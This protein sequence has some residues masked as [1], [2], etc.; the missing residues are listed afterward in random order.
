MSMEPITYRL[1]F[2]LAVRHLVEIE[3]TIPTANQLRSLGSKKH[4]LPSQLTLMMSVWT[5]GSYLVREYARNIES[6]AAFDGET[7]APLSIRK[8]DKNSWIVDGFR[9]ETIRVVYSLYCREMSVRTNWIDEEF[10]LINGAATFLTRDDAMETPHVVEI[11]PIALWPSIVSS[12]PASDGK[13][14]DELS[15]C[16]TRRA[17]S[18]HELVDNPILMGDIAIHTFEV[19]EKKHYFA[20]L[21]NQ[22]GWDLTRAVDDCRKIVA[23]QHGFWK[24]VPYPSYWFIN[25]A[26][27]GRGGLEHDNNTVLLTDRWTMAKPDSYLDWLGLVSHEFFHTWNVRRLRP[28]PLQEYDYQNEQYLEE[29][30]IAEG[31]TSYFDDLFVL[32]A[33][34]STPEEYLGLL[35][36]TINTVE[37]A[38]GKLVQSLR[39]SSWDTW[40]KLYRPDENTQN[41]RISY[42]TKGAIVAFLLDVKLRELSNNQVSLDDVMRQMWISF[43]ATGYT[44]A[45]FENVVSAKVDWDWK[46]WFDGHIHRAEQINYQSA[47]DWLGLE[48]VQGNS[49]EVEIGCEFAN[50]DGRWIVTKVIRDAPGS[51]SGL[52]VDDE[53]IAVEG[54]RLPKDNWRDRLQQLKGQSLSCTVARRGQLKEVSVLPRK[55]TNNTLRFIEH[56]TYD[57]HVNRRSWLYLGATVPVPSSSYFD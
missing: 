16:F 22:P 12:L 55:R 38:P 30:W 49:V 11:E 13:Q 53:L 56:A 17:S 54:W 21:G 31:I 34:L 45:D 28:K 36:K 50:R 46:A 10:A 8:Q 35:N 52:Q 27:E 29:L 20:H 9:S 37:D 26:A 44:L 48:R 7:N 19:N 41:S 43:R 32:R 6:I 14:G 57:Q 24:E 42:Y 25:I 33:G 15:S 4:P 23:Q 5:P 18:F 40:I 1:R 39:D 47:Y 3:A 2:P 51:M